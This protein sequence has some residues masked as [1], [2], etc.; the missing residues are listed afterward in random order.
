ML[1]NEEKNEINKNLVCSYKNCRTHTT[2]KLSKLMRCGICKE[3]RYCSTKCSFD[4]WKRHKLVCAPTIVESFIKLLE[5]A[6]QGPEDRF[7]DLSS[8]VHCVFPGKQSHGDPGLV[9]LPIYRSI[10][11][12][13]MVQYLHRLAFCGNCHELFILDNDKPTDQFIRGNA[14]YT[15]SFCPDCSP[16]CEPTPMLCVDHLVNVNICW[17]KQLDIIRNQYIIYVLCLKR[18]GLPVTKDVC[19]FIKLELI[20]GGHKKSCKHKSLA[21]KQLFNTSAPIYNGVLP[22]N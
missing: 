10:H 14:R 22:L 12:K 2:N 7:I 9:V 8:S 19:S 15:V 1:S 11:V 6:S 13:F 4:D 21:A 18:I 16:E 20:E 17:K 5:L 3:V